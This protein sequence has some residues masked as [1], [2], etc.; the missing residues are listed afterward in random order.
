M[1]KKYILQLQYITNITLI[2]CELVIEQVTRSDPC[3]VPNYRQIF[4]LYKIL[5]PVVC[6]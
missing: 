6:L 1:W 4:K 5:I 2:N 3:V